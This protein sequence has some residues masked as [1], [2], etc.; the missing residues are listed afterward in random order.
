[1]TIAE[2]AAV[3]AASILVPFPY[4]I[5]DH[6]TA[7]ARWLSDKGAAILL[8]ESQLTAQSLAQQLQQLFFSKTKVNKIKLNKMANL[9]LAQSDKPRRDEFIDEQH[10]EQTATQKVSGYCAE[11]LNV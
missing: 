11:Y 2:L 6:Q 9:A 7:N 5:D 8:P 1:M 3:G 4:A 10:K